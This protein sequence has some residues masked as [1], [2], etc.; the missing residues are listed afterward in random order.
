LGQEKK[1][2]LSC[3]LPLMGASCTLGSKRIFQA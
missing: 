2:P 1:L 3:I